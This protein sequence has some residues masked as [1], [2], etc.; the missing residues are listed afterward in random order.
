M[1]PNLLATLPEIVLTVTGVLI[2]LAEPVLPANTSRKGLGWLAIFGTVLSGAAT[3]IQHR[4]IDNNTGIPLTAFYR[5]VQVDEF[6]IFFHLLI[7]AVVIAV[8]L[9]SLDYF[10]GP[11][12]MG[13]PTGSPAGVPTHAG[14]YFA[15]VCFGATGMM[16]MTCSVELL[17][18]FIVMEIS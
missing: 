9:A 1:S 16:F 12:T 4:A 15:L 8:L 17:I 7:A 2:M 5:S 10:E 13:A 11:R 18:F 14:E 3:W 6:S